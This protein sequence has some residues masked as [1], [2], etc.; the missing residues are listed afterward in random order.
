MIKIVRTKS[1]NEDFLGLVKLLDDELN[2]RYGIIQ[3]EYHK[4]NKTDN[5]DTAVIGYVNDIPAGCGCF[6]VYDDNSVEIKRMFVRS[7]FRGSGI[8]KMILL[9]LERWAIEKGF[10]KSIL[11][12]GTRQPEAIK[13]YAKL[14]YNKIDNYGQYNGMINSI[15]MSKDL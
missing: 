7:D 4:Y 3:L 8:A 10:S 5:L 1:N 11:E 15:C 2:S 14:G 12:T 13:F 9:E 6:K